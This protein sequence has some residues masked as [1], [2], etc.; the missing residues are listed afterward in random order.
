MGEIEAQLVSINQGA[1]L[2]NMLTQH[3]PEC[4]VH[5]MR[6]GVIRFNSCSQRLINASQDSVACSHCATNNDRMV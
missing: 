2:L 6:R 5:Q 1:F 3:L 4:L